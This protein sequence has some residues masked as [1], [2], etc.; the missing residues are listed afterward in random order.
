[1]KYINS[2]LVSFLFGLILSVLIIEILLR[3][4]NLVQLTNESLVKDDYLNFKLGLI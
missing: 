3:A 2:K 4:F 1:M